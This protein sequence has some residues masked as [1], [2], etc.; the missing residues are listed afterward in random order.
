ME[1]GDLL[2][3]HPSRS[4]G[5]ALERILMRKK[6]FKCVFVCLTLLMSLALMS[7]AKGGDILIAERELTIAHPYLS[8]SVKTGEPKRRVSL[9]VGGDKIHDFDIELAENDPDFWVFVDVSGLVG[10]KVLLQVD[11]PAASDPTVLDRI[12]QDD[13]IKGSDDL[14]RERYRPQFHFTSRRGWN[15]D[16]NG[17]VYLNGEYHLF[18]QHNPYG[19]NWGNMHWGHAVSAD[20]V[21][22]R[23]LGE[24]I[25]PDALGTIFSGSAVVD[26]EN[27]AGFQAGGAKTIVCIYTSAGDQVKPQVPFTQSIAFSTDNGRTFTKYEGNPVVGHIIGSNRDPKVI[28]HEPTKKWIMALYLDKNDFALLSSPDLKAWT[29]LSSFQIP[30]ASECPDI[31]D[32]PVDGNP[33]NTKWVIW[34][35]NGSHLIGSF[36]GEAFTAEG[37]MLQA[38]AG[39]TAYAAQTYSGIPESDGRRIQIPWLR[40]A[41]TGMPFN[42]QM[43]FPV[44]LTLR[45]TEDGIRLHSEPIQE[46]GAIHGREWSWKS[47]KVAPGQNLLEGIEGELFDIRAEI[48]TGEAAELGFVIRGIPVVY[49]AGKQILTCRDYSAPLR[50]KQGR[51]RLR[52]LVDRASIEIFGNDGRLY[53]PIGLLLPENDRSLSLFAREGSSLIETLTIHEVKSIWNRDVLLADNFAGLQHIGLPVSDLDRSVGFYGRLGFRKVM[54]KEFDDGSGLIKVAMMEREGVVMELYQL[55]PDQLSKDIRTRKDGHLDHIAF[56]VKDID[57]AFEEVKRAGLVPLQDRP[58][59]LDFWERGCRYFSIRG[60][61]GEKLEFNQIL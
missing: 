16:P 59:K 51:I 27:T 7:C 8:F 43:G 37:E 10:K 32:L 39:G 17:L 46:I 49:D 44:E 38:Y 12:T 5:V 14:Y 13:R 19:W 34:A 23:E 36:D 21:H 48:S 30:G 35:A 54:A 24:A 28:W 18:Y 41:M 61:D 9:T 60:P 11:Q 26:R 25:R 47:R 1:I 42:Q 53:M 31:F 56:N 52:I 22:W 33:R 57:K 50:P 3:H 15:N 40:C 2:L 58:V 6:S 20:L 4:L 55:P 29:R 45:T